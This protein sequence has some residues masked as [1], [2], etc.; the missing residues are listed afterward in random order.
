MKNRSV[1]ELRSKQ[2]FTLQNIL[3][4]TVLMGILSTGV[5]VV[6]FSSIE[7]SKS[8]VISTLLKEQME[9]FA[10]EPD[11]DYDALNVDGTPEDYYADLAV[12]GILS[13][14][15]DNVFESASDLTWQI[16]KNVVDGHKDVFYLVIFS[17]NVSDQ[18]LIDEAISKLN[19]SN[20]HIQTF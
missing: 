7:K 13:P 19:V 9:L 17:D 4:A 10:G 14:I 3:I 1:S 16:R 6:M 5:Y 2:G 20:S 11:Y 15:P 18:E 12:N 8:T